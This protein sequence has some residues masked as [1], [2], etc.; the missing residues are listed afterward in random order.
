[1]REVMLHHGSDDSPFHILRQPLV[2][3]RGED[4]GTK[5]VH[6]DPFGPNSANEATGNT[7]SK[8][9]VNDRSFDGGKGSATEGAHKPCSCKKSRCLKKY[10]E[11]FSAGKY[12]NGCYCTGCENNPEGK[13]KYAVESPTNG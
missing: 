5:R 1:M 11:C 6:Y 4:G 8:L 3:V 12:C 7:Q 9:Q 13:P 10:C 2:Q